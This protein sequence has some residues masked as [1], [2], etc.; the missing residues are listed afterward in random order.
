MTYCSYCRNIVN[1]RNI[2]YIGEIDISD[3]F[4]NG[5]PINGNKYLF[6]IH[7]I[8]NV[9]DSKGI[10]L[11]DHMIVICSYKCFI[12]YEGHRIYDTDDYQ[13]VNKKR[14]VI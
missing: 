3:K 14:K 5:I 12:H 11:Q 8:L 9:L 6:P 7:Y 4:H 13:S 1:S 2:Q 10:L